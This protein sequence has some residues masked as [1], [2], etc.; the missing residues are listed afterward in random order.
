MV[1]S[2]LSEIMVEIVSGHGTVS[3]VE[4][5]LQAKYDLLNKPFAN[6]HQSR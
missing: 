6:T 2:T 5:L 3:P 4:F 1:G